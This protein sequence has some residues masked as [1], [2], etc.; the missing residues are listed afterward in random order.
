MSGAAGAVGGMF[1]MIG[2]LAKYKVSQ[3][4]AKEQM[5][6]SEDLRNEAAQVKAPA[7]RQEFRDVAKLKNLATLSGMPGY[8]E[9]AAEIG[10]DAATQLQTGQNVSSGAD[11]LAYANT[12][13]QGANKDRRGL[14]IDDTAYRSGALSDYAGTQWQIGN[15]QLKNEDIKRIDQKELLNRSVQLEDS[16]T[17]NKWQGTSDAIGAA[18]AA[19][20]SIAG[21][22]AGGA[23]GMMGGKDAGAAT[24]ALSMPSSAQQNG[25]QFQHGALPEVK[26]GMTVVIGPDGQAKTI[27]ITKLNDYYKLGYKKA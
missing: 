23:G 7:L 11:Y 24:S 5:K 26:P 8:G 6:R 18:V 10:L 20:G 16:S 9:Y 19:G 13:N 21:S 2:A 3:N 17:A 12:V 27:P 14:K 15:E 4:L 1:S 25:L 22:F